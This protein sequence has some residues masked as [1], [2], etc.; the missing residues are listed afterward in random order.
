MA[1]VKLISL[2]DILGKDTQE[3]NQVKEETF[4]V[5]KLGTVPYSALDHSE[6]KVCKKDCMKMVPNGTGGMVP[7][8]DDD[9]LMV[10]VIIAAVDKDKR[11]NF[12]FANKKLLDKLGVVSAD[13]AVD[14]LVAPGEVFRWA[15]EIQ[16]LSG[17]GQKAKQ[18]LSEEVKN[19]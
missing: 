1:N 9:K 19:S 13:Q 8:L 5:E 4:E 16:N 17:F 2:E 6:Y 7:E 14:A 12:T 18:Q 3:L 10:K 11:S 15:V